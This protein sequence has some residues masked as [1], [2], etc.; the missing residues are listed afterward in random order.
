MEIV[1]EE[2]A[3]D[4]IALEITLDDTL[5]SNTLIPSKYIIPVG[6]M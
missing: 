2:I 1:F 3:S 5:Q 4:D 6:N